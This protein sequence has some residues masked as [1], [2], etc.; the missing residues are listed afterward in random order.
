M[1]ESVSLERSTYAPPPARFEAGTSHISGA[2]ALGAAIDYVEAIGRDRIERYIEGLTEYGV[3]ALADVCHMQDLTYTVH[4]P[5]DA[6]GTRAAYRIQSALSALR[7]P[8]CSAM[9]W[10]GRR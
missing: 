6:G 4:L 8:V 2:I 3:A 7:H 10:L 1:I 9:T 5:T